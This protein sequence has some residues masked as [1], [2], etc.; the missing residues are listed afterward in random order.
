MLTIEKYSTGQGQLR[1]I[2]GARQNNMKVAG[3]DLTAMDILPNK[4]FASDMKWD[5]L[6]PLPSDARSRDLVDT[7]YFYTQARYCIID[8]ARLREWHQQR[9]AIAYTAE[10]GPI[11]SQIGILP[12]NPKP[13]LSLFF[14]RRLFYMDNLCY[15]CLSDTQFGKLD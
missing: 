2:Q 13:Y 15:W 12:C 6:P 5:T 3:S 7:V 10:D 8:W 1:Q 4:T 11:E 14:P 9:F